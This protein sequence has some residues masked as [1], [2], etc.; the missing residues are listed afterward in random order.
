MS[1]KRETPPADSTS[2]PCVLHWSGRHELPWEQELAVHRE[3]WNRKPVLRRC[4]QRWFEAIKKRTLPG[5]T[6]E[7]GAGSGNFK[8]YWPELTSCDVVP[9]PWLDCC[10]DCSQMPYADAAFD[11]VVGL[12]VL[13]HVYDPDR[14]LG[15]AAR[16]VRPGG[17]IVLVEPYVSPFSRIVRGLF[18]HEIQDLSTETI[19]A[20]DKQPDE[21]NL[22]IPTLMFHKN[23]AA[24]PQR[25]PG[26]RIRE[27]RYSDNIVYPLTGGF[28]RRMLLPAPA[29]WAMASCGRP[30]RPLARWLGFKMLVV[31]EVLGSQ[32]AGRRPLR[33]RSDGSET[34]SPSSMTNDHPRRQ[35][36][37]SSPALTQTIKTSSTR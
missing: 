30:F 25:F 22:A 12:D 1:G 13:H 5:K 23:A 19:Y 14:A 10:C 17:R 24:F 28:T 16:V 11:N 8:Q 2:Q 18:H 33:R 26:L 6:L 3:V 15:E 31:L 7:I 34:S 4:Y 29:L 27:I 21:A 32:S 20:E 35:S 9:A 36:S 37:P